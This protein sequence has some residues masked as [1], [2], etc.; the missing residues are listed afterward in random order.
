MPKPE[1]H[2]G[3]MMWA[4]IQEQPETYLRVAERTVDFL[5]GAR[6][7]GTMSPRFLSRVDD[8]VIFGNGSSYH[9]ACLAREY[10]LNV[11]G[12]TA[13]AEY[14]SDA[15]VYPPLRPRR[16]LGVAFSHSGSSSDVRGAVK[17]AARQGVRTMGLRTSRAPR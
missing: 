1:R 14:A 4:E 15:F 3:S 17:R 6:P 2:S 8:V 10:F 5:I 13:R 11:T 16:T 9:A 7:K 12:I